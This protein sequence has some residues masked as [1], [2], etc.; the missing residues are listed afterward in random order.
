MLKV[1]LYMPSVIFM[2]VRNVQV[3]TLTDL[4]VWCGVAM[5]PEVLE[6]HIADVMLAINKTMGSCMST[7]VSA[8]PVWNALVESGA[9]HPKS[10]KKCSKRGLAGDWVTP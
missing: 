9:K 2:Q 1:L 5:F 3:S 10:R 8:G 4:L 6:V 7:L